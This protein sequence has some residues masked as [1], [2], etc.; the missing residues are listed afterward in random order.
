MNRTIHF[1]FAVHNH[2]PVGNFPGVME[3]AY[4][5][6]YA[7]FLDVV[8]R[9]PGIRFSLHT[10][11]PLLEWLEARHPEYLE[12]VKALVAAERCEIL[13]GPF[14]EPVLTMLP[15][16]DLLGQVRSYGDHL[17]R[18]FGCKARGA[19]IPERVWEQ[20]LVDPL[21]AAGVEFTLL[22]DAHFLAAGCNPAELRGPFLTEE[23]GR[24][25]RVFPISE[26]LRY[27]IPW[28]DPETTLEHLRASATPAGNRMLVYADDGEKFGGW[29]RTRKHVFENRWLD[30]FFDALE[31]NASW[32]RL[33]TLG[34]AAD[35]LP[36]A[37][38]VYLPDGSYREMGEW[39]LPPSS[40][41]ELERV[42]EE[43]RRVG[44]ETRARRFLRG[45]TW[46]NFRTRYA[47][48]HRMYARML[49]ASDRVAAFDGTPAE[50]E[51]ARKD[52]YRAQCNC[53]YW[54]GVFGGLYLPH[55]RDAVYRSLLSAERR[56][57]R[58]K[59]L[60]AGLVSRDLDFDGRDE[61]LLSNAAL[62]AYLKPSRG[63]HL[64]E[65]D[66][67]AKDFNLMNGLTRR[68][69]AY[70]AQV[71]RA[72]AMADPNAA[73]PPDGR[74]VAKRAG[75]DR[76]LAYDPYVREGFI[77]HFFPST[78]T[79][80]DL[81]SGRAKE[82]GDFLEEPYCVGA[83]AGGNSAA[84][85]LSRAG[86]IRGPEGPARVTVRK[87][88][89]L[90]DATAPSLDVEVRITNDGER[91]L[92]S[93]YGAELL[94]SLLAGDAPDR[95]YADGSGRRRGPLLTRLA[96]REE[97]GIELLDE[98]QGLA[99]RIGWSLPAELRVFPLETVSMSEGGLEG[100]YQGSIL[101]P[102]WRIDLEPGA[103]WTVRV[104]VEV[105]T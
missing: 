47:E 91:V 17:T 67:L 45:G 79:L 54:H 98:W 93:I 70:H 13:G 33:T 38:R 32:I 48:A 89:S 59:P 83:V 30:R 65:L 75:L 26:E 58:A 8:E 53:A 31:R 27:A 96:Y 88:F 104:T 34:E 12:R 57:R 73:P 60:E 22:D 49:E 18:L 80:E 94:F 97:T 103:S 68:P 78:P 55:L 24:V 3:Q 51:A 46:R 81:E 40:R 52:L 105:R 71:A 41:H 72:V 99:L 100:V 84:V 10:S 37:G 87:G 19:W 82:L 28:N 39:A 11:G 66:C 50:A 1:A 14:Y 77:D 6:A 74:P 92:S 43:L 85:E 95:A 7:P 20:S 36:P 62:K 35:I 76:L 21:V 5:D 64:Y 102:T 42:V 29:P 61:I 9:H 25:L 4:Q 56:C 23:L 90:R 63:G 15:R 16:R 2:Q 101:L 44:L 86:T 69:E